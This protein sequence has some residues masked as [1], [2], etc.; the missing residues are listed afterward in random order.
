MGKFIVGIDPGTEQSAYVIIEISDGQE[1]TVLGHDIVENENLH[2]QVVTQ[3]QE[4]AGIKKWMEDEHEMAIEMVASY[5]MTVGRTTF[6]TV[7][8]IG[9]FYEQFGTTSFN[10]YRYYKKTDI[11]PEIC[12]DSRAKDANIRQSLLD[13]FPA[14]G[15]GKTP[16]VGTKGKPGPLY[17]VKSHIWS[18]LAVAMTHAFKKDYLNRENY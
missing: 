18:A 14:T 17:G 2:E 11:N 1:L 8:W 16:Q 6:E 3:I 5:G 4:I 15:G 9:R 12:F 10:R 13:M 7:F